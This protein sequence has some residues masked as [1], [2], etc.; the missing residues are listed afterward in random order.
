M[1]IRAVK[2]V[3]CECGHGRAYQDEHTA[4]KALGRAQAKRDRVGERKGHR[5]GLYRENRYYQCEHGL[6]HLTALSRSE[7]LGAA[8]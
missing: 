1:T 7:Y 4:A 8:A 2:F 6:F 3:S 5:R